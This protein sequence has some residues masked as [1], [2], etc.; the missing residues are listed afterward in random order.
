MSEKKGN[1]LYGIG[2]VTLLTVL[3]VLCLTLFSVLALSSAQADRR[4]SEKSAA[5]VTAYYESENQILEMMRQI[6]GMWPAGH[7]RPQASDISVRLASKYDVWVDTEGDG[8]IIYTELPVMETQT[9]QVEA[10]IGP[11]GDGG[12]W[13]VRQ[14]QLLPPEQDEGDMGFLILWEP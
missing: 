3:L 14:W 6:E 4:L 13:E 5:S 8:L 9:L 2:G 11:G 12:R 10:Y 7:R 1:P